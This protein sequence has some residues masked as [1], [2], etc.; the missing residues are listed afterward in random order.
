MRPALAG[1][2]AGLVAALAL[3]RLVESQ[4][5]QVKARDPLV[6][7]ASVSVLVLVAGM[8]IYLP[9]RRASRVDPALVLRSE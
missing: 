2:A 5:F 4:L 8:S 7:I 6:F 1:I 9:A 3:A